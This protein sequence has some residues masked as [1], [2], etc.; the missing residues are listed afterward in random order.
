MFSSRVP[1]S[2]EANAI[3]RALRAARDRGH[4]LLDL[5]LTNPTHAGFRYPETLLASLS[6]SDALLYD[7]A[8]FGLWSARQAVAADYSRRGLRIDPSHIVLTASTSEAYSLLFKLLCEPSSDEVLVPV[9]S[10]PLFEHLTRLDGVTAVAY[11]LEYHG[12]WTLPSETVE[13]HWTPRTRAVL[14]VSPNNPT[15]SCLSLAELNALSSLCASRR[16]ALILDEVFADFPLTDAAPST[17]SFEPSCLTCH[18]GGLS[19][20]VGLPQVKLGWI[21]VEGPEIDVR[22][23]LERLEFICDAYLSV[24]TPVQVAAGSLLHQGAAV[25]AQIAGRVRENYARLIQALAPHPSIEVL[26]A[27]A[28]WS[29]VLRVPAKGPEEALVLQLIE[30]DAVVVHPGF[31][32]DFAHEAFLVV[33]LLTPPAVFEEG[34]SR[35]VR[36]V[37]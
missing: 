28:G 4:Q 24:S 12:R 7:P 13:R 27:E 31:F 15:S 1:R 16:A 14:G 19:K 22:V 29:A 36:R 2:I 8:P 23:A 21:A 6:S 10:Y 33:S 25:R 20:S 35:I 26:A 3:A 37:G 18:L 11:A 17:S 32:F 34:L 30:Q 5:T 9:P